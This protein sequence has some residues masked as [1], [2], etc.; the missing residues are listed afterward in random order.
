MPKFEVV[1]VTRKY[2]EVEADT[3]EQ[4]YDK[5]YE[6][7]TTEREHL[8]DIESDTE[9]IREIPKTTDYYEVNND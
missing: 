8:V 6:S 7:A 1:E 2:Y 4:A 3:P 9:R 5:V